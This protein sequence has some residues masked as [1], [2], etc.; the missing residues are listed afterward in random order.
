MDLIYQYEDIDDFF[1]CDNII[2]D[3]DFFTV[4]IKK[5]QT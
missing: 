4:L 3:K 1:D 2:Q 5:L